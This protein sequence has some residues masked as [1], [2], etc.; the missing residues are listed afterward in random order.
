MIREALG[1]VEF[2]SIAA[3]IEAM[4]EMI[5]KAEV[6]LVIGR[7]ICSGKYLA[8]VRGDVGAV[9]ESVERGKE[10]G[11]IHTVDGI[12][13][14]N[15][16]PQIFPAISAT[17]AVERIVSLGI[18]ETFSAPSA[19]E[20][21]DYSVKA[22][23]VQLIEIRIANGIG[24]KTFYTL[25]GVESDVRAAVAAGCDAIR[26]SGLLMKSVVIPSPDPNIHKTLM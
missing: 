16:H 19:I 3:G 24:G 21:A 15:V 4:D 17:T 10:T 2:N 1:L 25:T 22:A 9:S 18:V 6:E 8:I 12:V 13:I 7:T 23:E 5:K 11:G 14:P 26:D 20:A